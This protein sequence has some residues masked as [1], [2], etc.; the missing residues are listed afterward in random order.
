LRI[1]TE[2]GTIL[3]GELWR[4]AG[5]QVNARQNGL[6]FAERI[7]RIGILNHFMVLPA[8]D[9]DGDEII[10]TFRFRDEREFNVWRKR[11]KGIVE[12]PAPIHKVSEGKK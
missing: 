11:L 9:R 1:P 7:W 8:I 3:T 5:E 10:L 12:I 2:K 4:G 6:R